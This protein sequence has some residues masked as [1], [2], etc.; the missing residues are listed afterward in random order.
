[1]SCNCDGIEADVKLT[2]KVNCLKSIIY[3]SVII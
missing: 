1:M 2:N 3:K